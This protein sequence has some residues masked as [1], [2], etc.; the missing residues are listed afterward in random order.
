MLHS[1]KRRT[2]ETEHLVELDRL[3]QLGDDAS[4]KYLIQ[5]TRERKL[6]KAVALKALLPGWSGRPPLEK[7]AP[8]TGE[9]TDKVFTEDY[10][11][12]TEWTYARGN[13]DHRV[14]RFKKG[15]MEFYLDTGNG[16]LYF[17]EADS[18][19]FVNAQD[20]V[21][22]GFGS[23]LIM[24]LNEDLDRMSWRTVTAKLAKKKP[25]DSP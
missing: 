4:R 22:A 13:G 20:R 16:K 5:L 9:S 12:G 11:V 19:R 14:I 21:I 23:E 3:Q 24:T 1:T 10:M 18:W 2:L 8:N 15:E 7:P 17:E 6:D 25:E